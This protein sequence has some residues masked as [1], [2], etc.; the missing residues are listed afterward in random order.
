MKRWKKLLS[1]VLSAAM[2]V[3]TVYTM[4]LSQSTLLEAAENGTKED[5]IFT[6]EQGNAVFNEE[7]NEALESFT[8]EFL[9]MLAKYPV[10]DTDEAG[11]QEFLTKRLIVKSTEDFDTYGAVAEADGYRGI[12]ILQ[13]DTE[14]AARDAYERLEQ[15]DVIDYVETDVLMETADAG[16]VSAPDS[17]LKLEGQIS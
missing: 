12:T 14:E 4:P 15:D 3:S 16:E 9:D 6:D 5:T 13:Y 2:I 7:T 10:E 17:S 8:D 1:S 11:E